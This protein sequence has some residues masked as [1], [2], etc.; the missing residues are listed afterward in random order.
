MDKIFCEEFLATST[1]KLLKCLSNFALLFWALKLMSKHTFWGTEGLYMWGHYVAWTSH[2]NGYWSDQLATRCNSKVSIFPWHHSTFYLT[3]W[4]TATIA[5]PLRFISCQMFCEFNF[6]LLPPLL[7][8][9]A[10]LFCI[11]VFAFSVSTC[12]I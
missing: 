8:S 10:I 9:L 3:W 7:L 4:I 1:L 12:I 6:L 5:Q 2:V 11:P